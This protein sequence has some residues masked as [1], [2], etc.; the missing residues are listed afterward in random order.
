VFGTHNRLSEAAC[1]YAAAG[2][3]VRPAATLV[4]APARHDAIGRWI[5]SCGD[6]PC[7]APGEHATAGVD[8]TTAADEVAAIWQVRIPP[9]LLTTSGSRVSFWRVPR[10][11][12]A[13]GMRLFEQLRPGP[14]PPQLKL[15]GG[16][17]VVATLPPTG[18]VTL[19]SGVVHLAPGVP[20]LVPPSRR[21]ATNGGLFR[22]STSM[23]WQDASKFPRAPLPTAEDV[24][25]LIGRA[26]QE[27]FELLS[28]VRTFDVV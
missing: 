1:A 26:E 24:L 19:P 28:G 3:A 6:L 7:A 25:Q 18:D 11:S 2:I 16:D 17:W 12:G 14:W 13:E 10:V 4:R 23:R 15:P 8:W 9:N 22:W 20:V 21:A 27:Q 5:C